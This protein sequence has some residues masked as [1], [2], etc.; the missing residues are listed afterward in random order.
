MKFTGLGRINYIKHRHVHNEVNKGEFNMKTFGINGF[1]RIGRTSLRAWWK[2]QR[3]KLDLKLVNTSGSMELEA[4]IHLLKYDTNYG[5]FKEKIK[6][7]KQQS[8][9][10]VTD[11]NPVLGT[12]E[13]G[14]KEITFTAQRDPAKIPWQKY[15]VETVLESTG[16]FRTEEKAA[17]HFQGGAKNVMISAP[18]KGG[19]VSTA[20]IGVNN[21]TQD[22]KIFSNASCTTNCIAPVVKVMLDNFGIKKATM[23]TIHAYT[24]DQNTHDNSNK[25]DLRRARSAAENIIPTTTGAAKATTEIIPEL[26]GLFDGMAVRVPTPVGSLADMVFVT[27]RETSVEEVND[28]FKKA[29][30]SD[31]YKG[32]IAVTDE[33]I[34]SSDI[35]GRDE[36]SIVDL[37]LTQVI[38]GDLVKIVSW[39]DNE[40][41][42]CV[43][44]LEQV[45]KI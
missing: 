4:W 23:T 38:G 45:G 29:A 30:I 10:D 21:F 43:K 34:V 3:N 16:V 26:K 24:D 44:L 7:N 12:I 8:N 13:L 41:G 25:K 18:S 28:I 35:I 11:E 15:G 27:G 22:G 31:R 20:V 14:G 5:T 1:G 32:M 9:K 17:L 39:Y 2:K 6:V 19:N 42:Y 37:A 33:P 40:W 36:A